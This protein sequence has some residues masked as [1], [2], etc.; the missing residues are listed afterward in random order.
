M[1]PPPQQESPPAVDSSNAS[2]A[3]LARRRSRRRLRIVS[4]LASFAGLLGL[5]A[6]GWFWY[7]TPQPPELPLDAMEPLVAKAVRAARQ[8]VL[9]EPRSG[10]AWGELGMVLDANGFAPEAKTCYA[11]AEK[12]DPTDRRW[13]YLLGGLQF[14]E[15]RVE[16]LRHLRRAVELS[17]A[18]DFEVRLRL[19]QALID[20][21]QKE[22]A[23]KYLRELVA[24]HPDL[25]PAHL[26]L[27]LLAAA[28]R[29]FQGSLVFLTR[30]T[31]GRETRKKA[32][33][34]LATVYTALGR[35]EEADRA[36]HQEKQLPE[37]MLWRDP[38]RMQVMALGVSWSRRLHRAWELADN[39]AKSAEALAVLR[40]MV[41][42]CP[43]DIA[44]YIYQVRPLLSLNEYE[45]AKEVLGEALKIKGD[46]VDAN[47]Y[48][49]LV[50]A[51]EAQAKSQRTG[52]PEHAVPGFK[53]ADP[54]FRTVIRQQP[55]HARAHV[56]LG[57]SFRYQHQ[58]TEAMEEYRTAIRCNPEFSDAHANLAQ[59]L[60]DQGQ[61]A[62]ALLHINYALEP[63]P[64]HKE[65][66]ALLAVVLT[67]STLWK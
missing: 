60:L 50:L 52:N 24:E 3:T 15:D 42:E 23:E 30:A 37:D 22:E 28:R 67:R 40:E 9:E 66:L 45:E 54:F 48:M 32:W 1:N 19:A 2:P 34:A 27:G 58:L 17:E 57:D 38:L 4:L 16:G 13:P 20:L 51:M 8:R 49:G 12:L 7:T 63:S 47:F 14:R 36:R 31:K 61:D 59:L 29:D 39:A 62:E 18:G 44:L 46:S 53:A 21:N 33:G 35:P 41:Q 64:N 43:D 55:D 65:S 25:L 5:A 10:D 26:D 6:S 56:L 11:Q